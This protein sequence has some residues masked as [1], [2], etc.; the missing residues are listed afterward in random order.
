MR[1]STLITGESMRAT[2]PRRAIV[3][4]SSLVL[5]GLGLA[6]LRPSSPSDTWHIEIGMAITLVSLVL[7][8]GG[9]HFYGRLGPQ[10]AQDAD[11]R[12]YVD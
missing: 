12:R 6:G 11:E 1:L 9:I 5:V 4:A 10:D 7:L 3:V 2:S 8:I